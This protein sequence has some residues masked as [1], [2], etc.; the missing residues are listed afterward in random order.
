MAAG[1]PR[2]RKR[3]VTVVEMRV[4]SP[5]ASGRGLSCISACKATTNRGD[6]I[7]AGDPGLRRHALGLRRKIKIPGFPPFLSPE[8]PQNPKP[9]PRPLRLTTPSPTFLISIFPPAHH[10]V[11]SSPPE[12]KRTWISWD[13]MGLLGICLVGIGAHSIRWQFSLSPAPSGREEHGDLI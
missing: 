8:S 6:A 4:L 3:Y 12:N 11:S 13:W 7:K 10:P 9:H 1:P 2:S 5:V